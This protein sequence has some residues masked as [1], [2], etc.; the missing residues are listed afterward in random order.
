MS[1]FVRSAKVVK[2]LLL[3]LAAW[4]VLLAYVAIARPEQWFRIFHGAPHLD[5]Q[6]LLQ[7]TG[8]IWVAFAL[9]QGIAAFRFTRATWWLPLVAGVRWTELFSDWT[10]VAMADSVTARGLVSLVL[11]PPI[12]L[13]LGIYLMKVYRAAPAQAPVAVS[14]ALVRGA[15]LASQGAQR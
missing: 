9:L 13:V 8:A 7:R 6:A 5:P 11:A 3:G 2:Y 4:D 12:N 1:S 10:Y 14:P 15:S